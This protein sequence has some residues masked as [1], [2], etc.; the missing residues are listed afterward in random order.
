MS[1]RLMVASKNGQY[2]L[3]CAI[4]CHAPLEEDAAVAVRADLDKAH[5]FVK[6]ARAHVPTGC[7]QRP[8]FR[9]G[10]LLPQELESLCADALI[11]MIGIHKDTAQFILANALAEDDDPPTIAPSRTI[12]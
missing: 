6:V 4:S 8:A 1:W 5:L 7:S 12:L 10:I 11:L 3:R 2:I 9:Q